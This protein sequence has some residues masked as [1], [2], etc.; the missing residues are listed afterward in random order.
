MQHPVGPTP[1]RG[2]AGGGYTRQQGR[3]G[4][5][6]CAA[7]VRDRDGH[8]RRP[9][10]VPVEPLRVRGA[11]YQGLEATRYRTE[12]DLGGVVVETQ[13]GSD[14]G[15]L[16]VG[17]P[18]TEHGDPLG[19]AADGDHRRSVRG[20]REDGAVGARVRRHR[21]FRGGADAFGGVIVR[22]VEPVAGVERVRT[23]QRRE[24]V[25][26]RVVPWP[27][28]HEGEQFR[29]VAH[30]PRDQRLDRAVDHARDLCRFEVVGWVRHELG[31]RVAAGREEERCAGPG[32]A[33]DLA[34]RERRD[35]L[36]VVAGQCEHPDDQQHHG[37]GG[38][39]DRGGAAAGTGTPEPRRRGGAVEQRLDRRHRG[40]S[41]VVVSL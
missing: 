30:V 35:A 14:I 17:D 28:D 19:A 8:P 32:E 23:P 1:Q 20:G 11:R 2:P 18:A 7:R 37:R 5:E 29:L 16:P 24:R 4:I 12:V 34:R 41:A 25:H 31:H 21:Q 3:R 38:E 13:A 26:H 15:Q 40:C 10:A 9:C 6:R 36:G 22:V 27:G 39:R 33:A